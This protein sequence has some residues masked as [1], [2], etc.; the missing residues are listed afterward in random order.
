L[1]LLELG[2]TVAKGRSRR[3]VL[4][5]NSM[6]D[7]P[8]KAAIP[9]TGELPMKKLGLDLNALRVDRFEVEPEVTEEGTVVANELRLTLRTCGADT[10]YPQASCDTGSPCKP[11]VY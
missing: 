1:F 7:A 10:C 9:L 8:E 4:F 2:D 6:H 5:D 3:A 11:C